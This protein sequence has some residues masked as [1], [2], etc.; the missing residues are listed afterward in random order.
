MPHA[1]APAAAVPSDAQRR[2]WNPAAATQAPSQQC[3]AILCV[4]RCAAAVQRRK[5]AHLRRHP[6]SF[7]PASPFKKDP[8]TLS[9]TPSAGGSP[10]AGKSRPARLLAHSRVPLHKEPGSRA[11]AAPVNVM[12]TGRGAEISTLTSPARTGDPRGGGRGAAIA[13]AACAGGAAVRRRR[14]RAARPRRRVRHGRGLRRRRAAPLAARRSS[15]VG[16]ARGSRPRR[17]RRCL[18]TGR[19]AAGAWRGG[20]GGRAEPARA[21][22]AATGQTGSLDVRAPP[23]AR[24]RRWRTPNRGDRRAG[25]RPLSASLTR[26]GCCQS[27]SL[28]TVAPHLAG[29]VAPAVPPAGDT[30]VAATAA[31]RQPPM[32]SAVT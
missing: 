28:W 20:D 9:A 30:A 10:P 14:R 27:S 21:V 3:C 1:T 13:A 8:L 32:R 11:S 22:V 5:S 24:R 26:F 2:S 31:A 18:P 29:G 6:L 7:P 4:P 19:N 23:A 25:G 17:A 12:P 15:C 16:W